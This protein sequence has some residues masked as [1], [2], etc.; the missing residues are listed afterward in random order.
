MHSACVQPHRSVLS[1]S[2]RSTHAL[3]NKILKA[4]YLESA[5][6]KTFFK[7]II[8]HIRPSIKSQPHTE[9]SPSS[10][11][12]TWSDSVK[13]GLNK[14]LVDLVGSQH[15]WTVYE[16]VDLILYTMW[17]S[18]Q[19]VNSPQMSVCVLVRS[20]LFNKHPASYL[21]RVGIKKL[22]LPLKQCIMGKYNV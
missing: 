15:S 13:E 8:Q 9:K 2:Q 18:L 5:N 20:Q 17:S 22:C 16:G 14:D 7:Y 19:L 21:Y 3:K 6:L 1:V 10:L 4:W 11:W 12:D